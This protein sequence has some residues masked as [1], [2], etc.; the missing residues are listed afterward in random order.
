MVTTSAGPHG[1]GRAGETH[2][3]EVE[4]ICDNVAAADAAE[5]TALLDGGPPDGQVRK[6]SWVGFE[7]F[8]GLPWWRKPSVCCVPPS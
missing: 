7:D 1:A 5:T 6:D 2:S 3:D 8:E 4:G